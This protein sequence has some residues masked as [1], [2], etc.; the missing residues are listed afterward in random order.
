MERKIRKRKK[1]TIFR[2]FLFPL[3]VIMLVQSIVT[4]GTLVV[5]RTTGMLEEYS[6]NMMSRLVENRK[7]VL[8]NDMNQRWAG[9]REQD[10]VMNEC[11]ETFLSREGVELEEVLSSE[12]LKDG[13]LELLVPECLEILQNNSTTGVFL[14]LTGADMDSAGDFDGFFIRDSDPDINP[15]NYT[16]LLLER[17]NKH[18]S[19]NWNIPLDTN[20]TTHFQMD[21]RGQNPADD[22]FYEPWRAGSKTE[23][24]IRII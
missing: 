22:Y 9:I 7:V 2:I 6:S 18:L 10:T 20:W 1:S 11:L 14:I 5:R 12:E 8:Q 17:G 16:D 3:I 19:R 13:F 23:M 4:I 15:E 24:R 21:G